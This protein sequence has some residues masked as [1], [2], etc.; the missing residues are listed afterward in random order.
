MRLKYTDKRLNSMTQEKVKILDNVNIKGRYYKL[1]FRSPWPVKSIKAGQFAEVRVSDGIEPLL[2]KPLSFHSVKNGTVELLY[3]VIGRGT[4]LLSG[5]KR[6][7]RLDIIGPLGNGFSTIHHPPSTAHILVAG[8]IGAAPLLMLAQ[9][10]PRAETAILLGART[11]SMLLCEKEFEKLCGMVLIS[12]DDGTCGRRGFVTELLSARLAVAGLKP[13]PA[14][15]HHAIYACGP[16]AMLE[17]TAA[18]AFRYGVGCQVLLEEYMACGTGACR[19]C[20]VATR[21]GYK[22]VCEDGPVFEASDIIWR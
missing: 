22:M 2:R 19:G 16:R 20:A 18:V 12:T 14:K 10:L 13:A 11:K 5:R 3:E 4:G 9:K 6:G 21:G 1:S 8:G 7:E 17:S 15:T